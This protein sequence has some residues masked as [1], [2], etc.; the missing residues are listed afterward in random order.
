MNKTAPAQLRVCPVD[1]RPSAVGDYCSIGCLRK[2]EKY[3][4]ALRRSVVLEHQR[5]AEGRAMI[6]G[7]QGRLAELQPEIDA[8]EKR[9]ATATSVAAS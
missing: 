1:F 7:G 4:D 9:L 5:V 8:V 6:S 2:D 3:A